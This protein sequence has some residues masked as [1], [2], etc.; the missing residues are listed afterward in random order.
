[1]SLSLTMRSS[2]NHLAITPQ[3]AALLVRA[4]EPEDAAELHQLYSEPHILRDTSASPHARA[5]QM[6]AWIAALPA[7]SH[8]LVA[9]VGGM[10]GGALLLESEQ[11]IALRHI[12]HLSRVGVS[13]AWQGRG[14][15]SRLLAEA[16]SLADSWLNLLRLELMVFADN[17]AAISLYRKY[18]FREEGRL[19][20]YAYRDGVYRD[21]LVMARLRGPLAAH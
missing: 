2:S 5:D 7:S 21:V 11:H 15:G 1:M 17:P 20:G 19:T 10:I 8:L 13:K 18:G 3:S 16:L 4:A 9:D 6:R 14:L 12:G